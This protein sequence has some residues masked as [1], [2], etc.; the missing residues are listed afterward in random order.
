MGLNLTQK[1]LKSHLVEGE[2]TPGA[3]IAIR[4][5]QTLTQDA[6]GTMAYLQFEAMELPRVKTK[7]SVSYVDHNTLQTDF[8]NADDHLY[9]Q[10]VAA[11]YGIHFSRPG[12]G[13]CHQ[14]HLERFG[15]PGQ[16]LLGSDSHTPTQGGL[17]M[18]AI[19]A[20]GLDV[21]MAMGGQP[22]ELA[23]PKVTSIRLEGKLQ[24]FV[25]AKDVILEVLRVLTVKGGVGKIMEYTGPG[26]KSLSVPDRATITNMGAELGATTSVFPSDAR[27]LEFLKAQKRQ[28]V[29]K[30]LS[31]DKD[32]IYEEEIVINL[33]K[34]EP[35]VAQPHS[36]DNV[37][38]VKKLKGVKVTQ[39]A[40]GSCTNSSYRDLMAV[41]NM[42]KGKTVHP[43]L[44]LLVS[45]GS[46]QVFKMISDNGAL[47]TL[48]EAGA[49]VLESA[50]G[51]CIGMGAAPNSAG[52]SVRTFNRNFKG[53]SGTDDAGV[54]LV[55]P[56]TAAACALK[57]EIADPRKSGVKWKSF[58]I[59]K[60]YEVNDNMIVTPPAPGKAAKVEII[61]GPN[62][63]PL[64]RFDKLPGRLG[65]RVLLKT[66]DNI[67]TDDIMPAGAKV[68]P[69]RSNIPAISEYVFEKVDKTFPKRAKEAG[70]GFVIG[71]Q[72]YGQGSSREH[73]AI[74]PKYLGVKAVIVKS[75]A[76]IHMANLINFGI[77][78]LQFV[79]ESDYDKIEQGDDLDIDVTNLAGNLTLVNKTK[80]VEIP[81]KTGMGGRDLE[82][83]KAGGL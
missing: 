36:P 77:L 48:I 25:S 73:A 64:P 59:P 20:G 5:D 16:T 28:K 60:S 42:L 35:M 17:G 37:T 44:S 14:V 74:A 7:L 52:V 34:L 19:G 75:F 2:L 78:P 67:T 6:T 61:R 32:A 63:A 24:P 22:F 15:V 11:R 53:R 21:A 57:G 54:Y 66:G 65:G 47:A 45:P 29:W 40:I 72:N 81:V 82:V 23:C 13:I 4:I 55:S 56:E 1:I 3:K 10:S 50:C 12:N 26:V 80:G 18:L 76:R 38:E 39:V 41:A 43:G 70:G 49:R 58:T 51:P 68:L 62:I 71:G 30:E 27:T 31:A 8:K 9:L 83:M 33:D 79:N 46:K 69:L